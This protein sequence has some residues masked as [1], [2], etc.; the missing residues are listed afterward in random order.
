E[1]FKGIGKLYRD[2]YKLQRFGRGGFVTAAIRAGVPIIP[3]SIV[4][5]EEIYPM[6]ADV[7]PVARLLGLPYAPITPLFPWLGPLG[8]V[9]LPS[10]WHIEFGEPIATD[11]FTEA[12]ADDP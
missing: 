12:D 3:V 4:G 10:K 2:R 9:P 7:K 1:G 11:R 5:A 8:M 6:L